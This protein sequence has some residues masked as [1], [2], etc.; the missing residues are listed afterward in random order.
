MREGHGSWC[1]RF[2]GCTNCAGIWRL[3]GA[4]ATLGRKRELKT[5]GLAIKL[6]PKKQGGCSKLRNESPLSEVKLSL[7]Y[8][9]YLLF[10]MC[11]VSNFIQT[12]KHLFDIFKKRSKQMT[13]RDLKYLLAE[14]MVELYD[15]NSIDSY[16][17][18]CHNA[19]SLIKELREVTDGWVKGN[20]I[21]FARVCLCAKETIEAIKDDTAIDYSFYGK[22]LIVKDLEELESSNKDKNHDICNRVVYT[23]DRCIEVNRN[24]YIDTLYNSINSIL[25]SDE[26]IKDEDFK[27]VSDNLN[28]LVTA[29]ACALINEGYSQRHLYNQSVALLNNLGT[30]EEAFKRFKI[31]HNHNVNEKHYDVFFKILGGVNKR[32]LTIPDFLDSIPG[33]IIGDAP[34]SGLKS[35]V[36]TSGN[37]IFYHCDVDAHDS[38]MAINY[39]KDKMDSVID[40]AVLGYSMIDVKLHQSVLVLVTDG[41]GTYSLLRSSRVLD[42]SYADDANIA[43]R[44]DGKLEQIMKNGCISQDV[45]DR[46][47][48]A[49]RHLRMGNSETDAG[50]QLV[51]YWVA[52]EFLFSSPRSSDS[53]I[54]RLEKNLTNILACGYV[55]RRVEY[56]N[57]KMIKNKTLP[58]GDKWWLRDEKGID[59]LAKGQKSLLMRYHILEMKSHLCGNSE[60]VKGFI[61]SHRNHLIWQIYRTYRYRNQLIHEAAILPGLDNVIR[62]LHYY[63]IYMLNQMIGY[64]TS[65]TLKSVNMDSFFYE[66]GQINNKINDIVSQH[67]LSFSDRIPVLMGVPLYSELIK[68]NV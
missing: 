31:E 36:N 65:T 46:L 57:D 37:W 30:F 12:N 11:K 13:Y 19:L 67:G 3:F 17:V 24:T 26:V 7:L 4:I 62:Y 45:K 6:A 39:A 23:L 15:W 32:L 53:T 18:R 44:I 61:N 64:F 59:S 2:C 49:L 41:G 14:R 10:S 56:L 48:S 66:Y 50:Q 51:N 8:C 43:S 9:K 29:L 28:R 54:T 42:T 22:D 63:L 21:D 35:F 25:D 16:R 20:I 52:L 33:E 27:P 5:K 40:K 68:K 58:N 1:C 38:V 34:S 47:R 60:K 55:R